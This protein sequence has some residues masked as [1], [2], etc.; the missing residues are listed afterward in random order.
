MKRPMLIRD[1]RSSF[2][3]VLIVMS[4][5]ESL[6]GT[7][8]SDALLYIAGSFCLNDLVCVFCL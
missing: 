1:H 4:D 3:F 2:F 6:S 8:A 7:A 5:T